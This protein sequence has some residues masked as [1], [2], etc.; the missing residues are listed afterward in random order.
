[1]ALALLGLALG[2]A[3]ATATAQVVKFPATGGAYY[4]VWVNDTL[5]SSHTLEKNALAAGLTWWV[6]HRADVV[7]VQPPAS[8]TR[9]EV[10]GWPAA[11]VDTVYLPGRIDTVLVVRVDT[12]YLPPPD[13]TVT[14]AP[15]VDTTT[16]PVP[17]PP[18]DTTTVPPPTASARL[19]VTPA[20][21]ATWQQM[22]A[23]GH[24][25]AVLADNNCKGNR[26]GDTGLWC[27]W[28][29]M[30]TGDSVA[31]RK[32]VTTWLATTSGT[33]F[34]TI[35]EDFIE[36]AVT[37]DWLCNGGVATAAE[38]QQMRAALDPWKTTCQ[39][40]RPEDG[41]QTIGC[42]FGRV[43]YAFATGDAT[44]IATAGGLDR[45]G[46]NRSTQRNTVG[47]YLDAMDG[48]A[49]GESFAYDM[50]T[51]LL[52]L[53]GV[54]AVKTATGVDHFPEFPV[55]DLARYHVAS[56]TGDLHQWVQW[57][58]EQDPRDVTG[59]LFKR[60]TLYGAVQGVTKDPDLARLIDD[61][62]AKYGRT[63]YG[64]AEP[65]ARILLFVDPYAPRAASE[66]YGHW[67]ANGMGIYLDRRPTTTGFLAA[68]AKTNED[69]QYDQTF[70]AELYRNGTW[71][72][73]TPLGYAGVAATAVAA[74]GISLAGFGSLGTRGMTWADSGTNWIAL[75]GQ[76]SG[77]R[78]DGQRYYQPPP[79]VG[80]A[81]RTAIYATIGGTQVL[82]TRDSVAFT[83]PRTLTWFDHYRASDQALVNAYDGKAW[84][85]WH[86]PVQPTVSGSVISWTVNG[87]PV[88]IDLYGSGLQTA[89]YD[90]TTLGW[91]GQGV[92][93]N[94]T[95]QRWH[96]KVHAASPVLWSVVQAGPPCAVTVAGDTVTACGQQ[97]TVTTAGVQAT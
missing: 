20:R 48:G 19:L 54:E 77:G 3:C 92:G 82:I 85:I 90:E 50:G 62:F 56:T 57:W 63:G 31:G 26:Y 69:H 89:T 44:D 17:P 25:L 46:L 18:P 83:D 9:I 15:P 28:W 40:I 6:N 43:A 32:A 65:W 96:V 53:M 14:P 22:V 87:E 64:S 13:T 93:V 71:V 78:Y 16:V 27:A 37:Y 55:A 67:L 10:T 80:G 79:P 23:D 47:G 72:L 5:L 38:C 94:P 36:K 33:N 24:H 58:D 4:T 97:F 2:G 68:Y 45:T 59:R 84:T 39:S 91:F 29:W 81:W 75:G 51:A 86:A 74:N 61:L 21:L 30:A 35:R 11:G 49:L 52:A 95:E 8:R 34:N 76:T 12:L 42:Y 88:R 41:D 70:D 60:M 66:W 1:M 73:P 7:E